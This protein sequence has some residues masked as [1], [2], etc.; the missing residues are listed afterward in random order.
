MGL[1][2]FICGA[3]MFDIKDATLICPKNDLE[4][5]TI[6]KIAKNYLADSDI[7]ASEQAWGARLGEEPRETFENLKKYV[8]IVEMP[9]EEAEKELT[10]EGHRVIIIDHHRY[11][12]GGRVLDRFNPL[13]SLEQFARRIGHELDEDEKL[14]AANDTGKIFEHARK[15]KVSRKVLEEIRA[16]EQAIFGYGEDIRKLSQKDYDGQETGINFSNF[17]MVLTTIDKVMRIADLHH[18]ALLSALEKNGGKYDEVPRHLKNI[19]ILTTDEARTKVSAV[20]F[21]GEDSFRADFEALG[22][23]IRTDGSGLVSYSG[24]NAGVSFFWGAKAQAD[25]V[26]A[27]QAADAALDVLL[28]PD[29][30][31]LKFSTV[32]FYPFKYEK[33]NPPIDTPWQVSTFDIN[34]SLKNYQ[35]YVYF[36]SYIRDILFKQTGKGSQ[37]EFECYNYKYGDYIVDKGVLDVHYKANENEIEQLITYPVSHLAIHTFIDNL[38]VLAIQVSKEADESLLQGTLWHQCRKIK[39]FRSQCLTVGQAL[40]FNEIARKIYFSFPEQAN[41]GMIPT[42]TKL[43]FGDGTQITHVF[44]KGD[45]R[46]DMNMV[47]SAIN[48]GQPAIRRPRQSRTINELLKKFLGNDDFYGVL[49][50]RMVVYTFFSIAGKQPADIPSQNRFDALFS[51]ILYVDNFDEGWNYHEPFI[52]NLM[53]KFLLRRWQHYGCLYG[54]TR[55]SSAYVGFGKN[56][57][58]NVFNHFNS[59]YY[60]MAL[61]SLCYRSFLLSFSQEVADTTR[62]L[63]ENDENNNHR[64]AFLALKEKFMK[65]TNI[66]WFPEITNQDQGIELFDLYKKSFDFKNMYDE[67]KEEVDRA[68]A[69]LDTK[70][71]IR[72]NLLSK[73]IGIGGFVLGTLAVI[74]SLLC[75]DFNFPSW[76]S[77]LGVGIVFI[78]WLGI[79]KYITCNHLPWNVEKFIHPCGQQI[80]KKT[81]S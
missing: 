56:F 11:E 36:H 17:K 21:F 27:D 40:R 53:E 31:L 50:D 20:H 2:Q 13:S 61:F 6:L 3:S 4:S 44:E 51:R 46:L 15:G 79:L 47:S 49:D 19:L 45:F 73:K 67:V 42:R 57:I 37:S 32:F 41:C 16:E 23:K 70:D 64:D 8:I 25:D 22:E 74:V 76:L 7:I 75:L 33:H 69:Y 29:R 72:L 12:R 26:T 63:A 66:Y 18:L 78:S 10:A 81:K 60:Q 68:D 58:E 65:F 54:F 35:E 30:P 48:G 24:G 71:Q 34:T 55:Y 59:M 14:I 62:T 9:D 39:I 77:L 38:A 1:I 5:V 52:K 28:G 80:K 43:Q